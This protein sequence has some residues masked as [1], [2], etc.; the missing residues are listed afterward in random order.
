MFCC[1]RML[2]WCIGTKSMKWI[3][4]YNFKEVVWCKFLQLQMQF[5]MTMAWHLPQILVHF[6][7]HNE[8]L[9]WVKCVVCRGTIHTTKRYWRH[10]WHFG[11]HVSHPIFTRSSMEHRKYK[12]DYAFLCY[13]T[14]HDDKSNVIVTSR[15]TKFSPWISWKRLKKSLKQSITLLL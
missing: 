3:R 9:H 12:S 4:E 11:S 15:T 8:V 10:L 6:T 5:D 13:T 14:K 1:S 2:W 7:V